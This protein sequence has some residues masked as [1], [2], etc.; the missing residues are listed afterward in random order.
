[1]KIIINIQSQTS[2][3]IFVEYVSTLPNF[4]A[5]I[6]TLFEFIKLGTFQSFINNANATKTARSPATKFL[7]IFS[8]VFLNLKM[9]RGGLEPPMPLK[10][11]GF[12]VRC[13]SRYATGAMRKIVADFLRK[14]NQPFCPL[15]RGEK[16]K[17]KK[18][19]RGQK[20]GKVTQRLLRSP[21]PARMSLSE[22]RAWHARCRSAPCGYQN[23]HHCSCEQPRCSRLCRAL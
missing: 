14:R 19:G 21:S 4:I 2:V 3:Q 6:F 11:R 18:G 5:P 15:E 22:S 23:A 10:D 7:L 9:R 17:K 1:M 16:G 8:I 12:T 13:N 20:V